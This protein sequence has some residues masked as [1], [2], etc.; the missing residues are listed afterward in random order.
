M[1]GHCAYG[2]KYHVCTD[3]RLLRF[4]PMNQILGSMA[5]CVTYLEFWWTH[6]NDTP[7]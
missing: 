5:F 3:T 4:L 7:S 1:L 2:E 6:Q